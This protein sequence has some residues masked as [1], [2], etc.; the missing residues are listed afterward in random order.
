VILP[1]AER[2][3]RRLLGRPPDGITTLVEW[4][5]HG[6]YRVDISG[7]FFV[8]KIDRDHA[9]IAREVAGQS[10]AAAAAVPVPPIVAH[11]RDAFAMRFVAGPSLGERSSAPAWRATGAALRT[12]HAAAPAP[13]DGVEL[14]GAGF[15]LVAPTWP[16]FVDALL[17]SS[18]DGCVD[19]LGLD[20]AAAS[21]IRRA[22]DDHRPLIEQAPIV[23]SHG[24]LQP[25]HVILG[26]KSDSVRAVIDWADHGRADPAWDLAVVT[27][28]D[29]GH[30][31]ALLEGYASPAATNDDIRRRRALYS[32]LRL[33]TEALWLAQHDHN[34]AATAAL[35]HAAMWR[36]P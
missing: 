24:D 4:P 10:R 13:G 1:S 22:F 20:R 27:L 19:D 35:Q 34:N 30:L 15:G 14:I 25:E 8:V 11:A 12:L 18:L 33:L 26:P 9:R 31:D 28:D 5:D 36:A 23:R 3:A 16:D 17:D 6:A 29:T 7:E 21:R 32:V 2:T